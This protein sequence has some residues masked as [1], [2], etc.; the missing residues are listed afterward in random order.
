[1]PCLVYIATSLDG[2]IA[3]DDGDLSWLDA[4]PPPE[5]V[6]FGWAAFNERVDAIL[7]GRG[8]YE[9][10]HGMNLDE[11]PYELPVF[12]ASTSLSSVPDEYEGK[13]ELI[14]GTPEQLVQ[15]MAERGHNS[16]YVDGGVLI[17]SF[18][19]AGLIDELTITRVPM[20]LGS[21]FPLFGA[22]DSPI[23]LEHVSTQS[24]SNGFAQST[25]RLPTE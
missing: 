25:Y 4:S 10:V 19:N 24:W 13:V 23:Q 12:V 17:T 3:A 5:G 14:T 21:G 20:L 7:M 15:L 11:W 16:I 8:T 18:L 9:A 1:M 22:L 6:D 2:Y